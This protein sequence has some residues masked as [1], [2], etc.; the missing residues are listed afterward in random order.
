M[1]QA[2]IHNAVIVSISIFG[3]YLHSRSHRLGN[4]FT[5]FYSKL[6]TGRH[7]LITEYIL[8]QCRLLKRSRDNA[9]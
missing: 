2:T 1:Q 6:V 7:R 8:L 4:E 5:F 9:V 3:R